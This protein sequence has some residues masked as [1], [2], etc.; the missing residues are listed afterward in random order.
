M[1]ILFI[2]QNFP[3]QFLHLAPALIERGHEVFALTISRGT[4]KNLAIWNGV[5]MHYYKPSQGSTNGI[6]PWAVDFETKV[7]RAEAFFHKALQM[8]D[9]GFTPDL[10]VAHPGWGESIFV[11]EVWP[12][13]KLGLVC[14]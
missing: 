5:S 2:H 14:K 4:D 9:D 1:K 11:K 12:K 6:H 8:K 10:V 7:I 3:G 13:I